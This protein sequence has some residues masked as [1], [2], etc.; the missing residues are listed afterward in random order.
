MYLCVCWC[1]SMHVCIYCQNACAYVYVCVYVCMYLHV[2]VCVYVCFSKLLLLVVNDEKKNGCIYTYMHVRT[3]ACIHSDV[4][5]SYSVA[6]HPRMLAYIHTCMP[7]YKRARIHVYKCAQIH[8]CTRASCN[9][10]TYINQTCINS[11]TRTH[12]N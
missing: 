9:T 12:T 5:V 11:H 8:S 1:V 6:Q 7:L 2:C 3:H 4:S 10:S